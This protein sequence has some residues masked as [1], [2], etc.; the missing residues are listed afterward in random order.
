MRRYKID[1]GINLWTQLPDVAQMLKNPQD[2][3]K[4]TKGSTKKLNWICPNCKNEVLQKS[5][6]NVVR[7]GL[8]CPLCSNT[9]SYGHR[10]INSILTDLRI[11]YICEKHF[12][13][14]D[15]RQYDTYIPSLNIILEIDGKQHFEECGLHTL[16][17]KTFEDQINNDCYKE[18]LALLNG[19]DSY[20]HID[21]QISTFEYIIQQLYNNKL[22]CKYISL[23]DVDFVNVK[24]IFCQSDLLIIK[25]MFNNGYSVSDICAEVH[26]SSTVVERKLHDLT[27][28]GLCNYKG[29]DEKR[30]KVVC[31]NTREIFSD[32]SSAGLK[33][34]I[35]PNGI[36]WCCKG[37]RNRKTAGKL[38]DGTKLKWMFEDDYLK[39]SDNEI[40]EILEL[41]H[42]KRV[43]NHKVVCL[44][45]G[46]IFDKIKDA[47]YIYPDATGISDCCR[48]ISKSSGIDPLTNM[49]LKWV[50]YS[51]YIQMSQDDISKVIDEQDYDDKRIVCL[52]NKYVF[53]NETIA[54]DWCG[55]TRS[56][57]SACIFGRYEYNGSHPVTGEKLRWQKYTD[58]CKNN[59]CDNLIY[60]D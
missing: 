38:E 10:L 13:W 40:N 37:L 22:F 55:V 7:C 44:N 35:D 8:S 25:D 52:N 36:S 4:V 51:E 18:D 45:T 11:E 3:Y 33:Y 15:G 12:Y 17:G 34:G 5:V 27:K 56:G 57:I 31:L 20:I 21:A 24:K 23:D 42:K 28:Q 58:Y 16:A 43:G 48:H 6:N 50:Y 26:L 14:S 30:K 1:K 49:K 19:I 60:Y 2:G 59:N 39:L 32:L 47:M 53:P 29:L 41:N 46:Q 9:R 54:A